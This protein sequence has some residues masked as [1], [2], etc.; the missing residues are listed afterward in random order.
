MY[1][2]GLNDRGQLGISQLGLIKLPQHIILP[3]NKYTNDLKD[4]PLGNQSNPREFIA[5][6]AGGPFHTAILTSFKRVFYSG[7]VYR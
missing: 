2:Y 6:I 7:I 5:K 3:L 4:N 1:G